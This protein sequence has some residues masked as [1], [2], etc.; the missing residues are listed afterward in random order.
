VKRNREA[1]AL[2]SAFVPLIRVAIVAGFMATLVLGGWLTLQGELLVGVY[3]TLVFMT[4]RLL[5][6]LTRLGQT[7]DL[8]QRA[9][10]STRRIF[11]LLDVENGMAD[12]HRPLPQDEV[13]GALQFEAV[14]FAYEAGPEVLR[15]IDLEIPA[16]QT[17]AIVGPPVQ[18]NRASSSCCCGSTIR[19]EGA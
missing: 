11:A 8:Y 7:L 4:Q 15:G 9:M 17:V 13:R 6:P 18:E 12:G 14:H 5:W 16:G 1:I 19:P 10:A 2:S 3:S